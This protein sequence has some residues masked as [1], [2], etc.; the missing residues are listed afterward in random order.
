MSLKKVLIVEDSQ[1][2]QFLGETAFR[3]FDQEIE[4]MCVFDGFEAIEAL[5]EKNYNPDLVLLD[6]NMPRMNGLEFL[7]AYC[8][9]A[10]PNVPPIVVMLT[11]SEQE[12][13]KSESLSY[14]QVKD[15]LIKPIRKDNIT[16][17]IQLLE[18]LESSSN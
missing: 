8:G 16:T 18:S 1:D 5:K 3:K 2:D 13:D 10:N 14:V 17:I 6:I 4:V 7:K 15:Y 12:S 9:D 11:S